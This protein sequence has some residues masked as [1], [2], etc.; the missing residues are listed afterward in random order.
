MNKAF[1]IKLAIVYEIL[2]TELKDKKKRKIN[3]PL[4]YY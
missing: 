2:R 1:I 4:F 3:L